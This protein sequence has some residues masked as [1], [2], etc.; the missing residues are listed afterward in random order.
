M[1]NKDILFVIDNGHGGVINGIP[2][3]AGKRSPD[4]G[5]GILHEGVSNR[6]LSEKVL[7]GLCKANLRAVN[8]VPEV[9]DISLRA[10]VDRVNA[11]TRF[12]RVILIS[13]HSDA[14]TKETANGWSAWTSFGQTK[15]DKVADILYKHAIKAKLTIREDSSDN[16]PDKEAN[17]F[18][19]RLTNCPAVLVENLF[20]TNKKD[21]ETLNSEKGQLKLAKIMIDT[22][23]EIAINGI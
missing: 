3:T 7:N 5:K 2:Q 19:L 23:K 20:F 15:S 18:L 14:W 9:T 21:Y 13:I 11:L 10:R 22:C 6:R 4:F 17:F 12:N 1:N 8:L 16:D